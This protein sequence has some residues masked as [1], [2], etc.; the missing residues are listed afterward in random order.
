MA[1]A[2]RPNA[3][4]Q[5]R[6]RRSEREFA[7]DRRSQFE[8]GCFDQVLCPVGDRLRGDPGTADLRDGVEQQA[9]GGLDRARCLERQRPVA[10]SVGEV[11]PHAGPRWPGPATPRGTV[12][13]SRRP[14]D[15]PSRSGRSSACT[16]GSLCRNRSAIPSAAPRSVGG[17]R[18]GAGIGTDRP[19]PVQGGAA[20]VQ[21][22]LPL[23]AR[24][25]AAR[26]SRMRCSR[27]IAARS[28]MRPGPRAHRARDRSSAG[29]TR[30]RSAARRRRTC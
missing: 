28:F 20:E 24:I 7:A 30:R 11:A 14:A 17:C 10:E 2:C 21:A 3:V 16:S 18:C 1:R 27:R 23:K 12:R 29:S 15:S 4:W 19:P 22:A 6:S 9:G 8:P 5:W 25:E 26:S 13:A